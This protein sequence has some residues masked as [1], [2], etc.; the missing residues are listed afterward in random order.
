MASNAGDMDVDE[1]EDVSILDGDE[2]DSVI[3]TFN[4]DVDVDEDSYNGV[5]WVTG[6]DEHGARHGEKWNLD[7]KVEKKSHELVFKKAT[8]SPSEISCERTVTFQTKITNLGRKDED[9]VSYYVKSTAMGVD[10]EKEDFT[11]EESDSYLKS[12]DATIPSDLVAG[13]YPIRFSVYYSGD[14]NDG[15]QGD[16][17]DV[18]LIVSDCVTTTPT[19]T[20]EPE[21]I[22][23]TVP[24]TVSVTPS[25]AVVTSGEVTEDLGVI[26]TTETTFR[27][28]S[29]YAVLLVGALL[30]TIGA[31]IAIVVK[32]LILG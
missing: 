11:I 9:E 22:I 3:L 13:T 24:E 31:G 20:K 27:D 28:S 21:E 26:E 25:G 23:V 18:D 8:V 1:T 16:L 5:V 19:V 29:L 30:T 7:W 6:E 12:F 32:L 14:E 4:I 17:K 15:V 2:D 10:F